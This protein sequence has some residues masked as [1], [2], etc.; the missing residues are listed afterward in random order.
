MFFSPG[1]PVKEKQWRSE[2]CAEQ[3]VLGDRA[4]V[5]TFHQQK[6]Q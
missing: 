4:A 6:L 5:T 3:V 2:G 1:H